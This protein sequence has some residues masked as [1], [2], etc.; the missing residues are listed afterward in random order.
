MLYAVSFEKMWFLK[1]PVRYAVARSYK[2]D[3]GIAPTRA[4]EMSMLSLFR[5]IGSFCK[6]VG[7]ANW[8]A[9]T[10]SAGLSNIFSLPE[11]IRMFL[12]N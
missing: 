3:H 9:Y 8:M 1:V 12:E 11:P 10:R 6:G 7:T 2:T 4:H 5:K